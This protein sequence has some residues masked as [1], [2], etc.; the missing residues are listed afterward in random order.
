[1]FKKRREAERELEKANIM[2]AYT[3]LLQGQK[4]SRSEKKL[5]EKT[6]N[7]E[8][9]SL[10]QILDL[11][12]RYVDRISE[13][14][15]R[16][17]ALQRVEAALMDAIHHGRPIDL[18]RSGVPQ[19]A[20]GREP[21]GSDS[22]LIQVVYDIEDASPDLRGHPV[23]VVVRVLQDGVVADEHEVV[24][25]VTTIG[26]GIDATLQ[27]SE[28]SG[29]SRQ[30][31]QL[32]AI[33]GEVYLQDLDSRNGTYVNGHAVHGRCPLETGD[34]LRIGELVLEIDQIV[35]HEQGL[36]LSFK[37]IDDEQVIQT[38][39]L[40]LPQITIGRS[41]MATIQLN[42]PTRKLSRLHAQLDAADGNLHITDL[43]SSN[44]TYLDGRRIHRR[45]RLRIGSLLRLG[46]IHL[47][48]ATIHTRGGV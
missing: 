29:I 3:R 38:H 28:S 4:L 5:L 6:S 18:A 17:G 27:F 40:V 33:A 13:P 41:S 32:S 31:I 47:Q 8:V 36:S 22:E 30:H 19:A 46:G 21:L 1:M 35:P 2:E 7:E 24:I 26:R 16:P 15:P 10:K 20:Y 12:C 44:G 48:I 43:G 23:H 45:T 11:V 9:E 25:P 39:D 14:E 37:Q 34:I 42:D